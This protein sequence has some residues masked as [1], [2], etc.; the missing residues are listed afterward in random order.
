MDKNQQEVFDLVKKNRWKHLVERHVSLF[1][2]SLV[3]EGMKSIYYNDALMTK[4]PPVSYATVKGML[5]TIEGAPENTTNAQKKMIE[6]EGF[7]YLQKIAQGCYKRAEELHNFILSKTKMSDT[8][9]FK[10]FVK[11]YLKLPAYL[12]VV[13]FAEKMLEEYLGN[14][15]KSKVKDEKDHKKYFEA[16][17]FIRKEVDSAKETRGLLEL[18]KEVNNKNLDL[19]GEEV[20][21]L[22]EVHAKKW[23]RLKTRWN[24]DGAYTIEDFKDRLK[25]YLHSSPQDELDKMNKARDH[26]EEL[27]QEFIRKYKL[28]KEEIKLIDV[29]KEYVYLRTF[30]TDAFFYANFLA[31]PLLMRIAKDIGISFEELGFLQFDEVIKKLDGDKTDYKPLIKERK[32]GVYVILID[33]KR[34]AFSGQ[35]LKIIDD[36]KIFAPEEA[37]GDEVKGS[38]AWG[39]KVRGIARIVNN[40]EDCKKVGRGDILVAVMTFPQYIMAMEKA[41]AFVTDEGGILSHAAIVAREM[42]KPCVISTRMATKLFKDGEMIEVDGDRGIVRRIK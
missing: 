13:V 12:F 33:D 41:A 32:K 23:A 34:Q 15:I 16:L 5:I 8:E 9:K 27:T 17:S 24:F 20:K 26:S 30:R 38:K 36:T 4:V 31:E 1:W 21:R 37:K 35:D 25:N 29:V 6:N 10:E 40:I 2:H 19:D 11:I 3:L 18:A 7:D 39:G 28:T 14:L 42:Q 22:L